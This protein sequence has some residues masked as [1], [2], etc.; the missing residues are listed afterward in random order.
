MLKKINRILT[1]AALI[2]VLGYLLTIGSIVLRYDS[3]SINGITYHF[4]GNRDKFQGNMDLIPQ[5]D[6]KARALLQESELKTL[7]TQL[8]VFLTANEFDF[9][10]LGFPTGQSAF[11]LSRGIGQFFGVVAVAPTTGRNRL[12]SRMGRHRRIS[13]VLAHELT[14][15]LIK[16]DLSWLKEIK[17]GTTANWIIEGYADYIAQES[18]FPTDLGIAL[19]CDGKTDPGPSYAYFRYRKVVGNLLDNEGL[20]FRELAANPPDYAQVEARTKQ[21]ICP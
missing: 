2:F 3:Y 8:H 15:L 12:I 5:F 19:F 20:T 10:V 16:V 17:L 13:S 18:S 4:Q 21:A 6:R 11:G 14:H 9:R 7:P 1:W